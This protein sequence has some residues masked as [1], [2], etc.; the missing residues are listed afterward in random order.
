MTT[1]AKRRRGRPSG[2]VLVVDREVVLDNAEI[3][4]RRDGASATLEAIAI[5]SGVTRPIVNA[6]IGGRNELVSALAQRLTHRLV[7]AAGAAISD[8]ATGRDA[9]SDLIRVTLET[10]EQDRELFLYV[11]G[12]NTSDDRLHFATQISAPLA[13]Q[14]QRWR[15]A[16]ELHPGVA[17]AWAFATIGMLNLV[18]LWWI[19]E[20]DRSAE[21]LAEQLTE[22][23]WSGLS[24]R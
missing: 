1:D 24:G 8:S 23:L 4:I 12:G 2:G 10:M 17:Q 22:L 14:L 18:A 13:Q 11:T 3:V 21:E 7:T 16:D 19:N 15:G 5:E 20:A 9:I 6:R